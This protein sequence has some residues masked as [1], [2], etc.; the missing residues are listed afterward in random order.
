VFEELKLRTGIQHVAETLWECSTIYQVYSMKRSFC[1]IVLYGPTEFFLLIFREFRP[2]MGFS[3][4]KIWFLIFRARMVCEIGPPLPLE[5]LQ[6]ICGHF[7]FLKFWL[8]LFI[9]ISPAENMIFLL[10]WYE[11]RRKSCFSGE[12]GVF[13]GVYVPQNACHR[14]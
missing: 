12:M 10:N 5:C 8:K 11:N 2:I 7:M 9:K 14:F 4:P 6:L 3:K 13:R 1:C